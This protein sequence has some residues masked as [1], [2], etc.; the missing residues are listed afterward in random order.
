ALGRR[1]DALEALASG[2]EK[3][4]HTA[5]LDLRDVAAVRATAEAW[6]AR[7]GRIDVLV[8]CAGVAFLTPVLEITKEEWDETL[9]T[10]LTG[11]FF[12]SQ[13][14]ARH[15]VAHG[16]GAI[17]NVSSVDAFIAESPWAGYNASKAG[18]NQLT[19]SMAFELGH[20]GLRCNAVAPGFTM[21]PMMAY[22]SDQATWRQYMRVIPA[23]RFCTPEEQARVVL[24]LASDDASYVNGETIR[25]D[26][27]ELH[28]FWSDPSLEPPVPDPPS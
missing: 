7:L 22:A 13:E 21:T 24:F 26:G 28:G 15:M 23:R 10:N 19:R 2:G 1:A 8:N 6:I 12:L 27:G 25:V 18:L 3:R 11:A 16:G 20:L 9:A 14:I 4:I 5:A 17:V